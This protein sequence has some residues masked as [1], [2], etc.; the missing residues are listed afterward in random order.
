MRGHS[1][2]V[3]SALLVVTAGTAGAQEDDNTVTEVFF[4]LDSAELSQRAT[5]KLDQA[6]EEAMASP[7]AKIVL[8][9][10]AD[11]RGSD[12]YNVGL[13]I[14]RAES[15]RDHL[16]AQGVDRDDIIMAFYGEDAPR[17]D[18]F[19]EDRRV[20]VELTREPLHVVVD[21]ALPVATGVTWG[22]PATTAEIEGP[23][24]A[25]VARE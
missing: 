16:V 7:G 4:E 19:A 6:A 2:S 10:H 13:S 22:E 20:S 1:I 5:E 11:P 23:R 3:A 17:R 12:A 15:V 9:G 21:R 25:Q 18:S 24:P 8:D 14:R